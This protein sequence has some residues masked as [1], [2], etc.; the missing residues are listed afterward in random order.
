LSCNKESNPNTN[1][2]AEKANINVKMTDDALE[3]IYQATNAKLAA[4]TMVTMSKPVAKIP[5][6][7]IFNHWKTVSRSSKGGYTSSSRDD[8]D[9]NSSNS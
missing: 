8:N 5:T 7:S 2:Q 6:M 3:A 4:T 1:K 9:S